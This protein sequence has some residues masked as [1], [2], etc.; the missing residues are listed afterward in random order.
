MLLFHILITLLFPQCA[1]FS[2]V[3]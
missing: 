3:R 2:V 1:V